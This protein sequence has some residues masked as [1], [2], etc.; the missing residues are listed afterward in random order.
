MYENCTT[1][2]RRLQIYASKDTTAKEKKSNQ[3][4]KPK[5][6]PDDFYSVYLKTINLLPTLIKE[7]QQ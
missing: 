2:L 1:L 3:F 5:G 4:S 7:S 6:T